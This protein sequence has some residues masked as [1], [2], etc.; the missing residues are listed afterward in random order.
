MLNRRHI[1]IKVM[2]LIY[3]FDGSESDDLEP[4]K[5][6]LIKSME[7]MY[8]LYLLILSLMVEIRL[9]AKDHLQKIQKKHLAT[10][11]DR[12]PSRKFINNSVLKNLASNTKL[13]EC[14]EKRKLNNWKEDNEYVDLLFKLIRNSSIF[15]EYMED[16]T[17]GFG[18]DARFISQIY[19]EIIAPNDKFY[20]YLE[21]KNLTW[22]DDY[23]VVNT[24][25]LKQLRKMRPN[26]EFDIMVPE[27]YKDEEDKQFGLDLLVK[28]LLNLSA[29]NDIVEKKTMNW[30]KDRIAKLDLVLLQMAICEINKFPS[31]PTKV[32]MNEYLEIAK[33]YSTPKSSVFINGILDNLVKE[34]EAKGTLNKAGRGLM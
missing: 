3:A 15:H 23:P 25:F 33:E 9:K 13:M 28:T 29:F 21:D 27:L 18:S 6:Q 11:S 7:G 4:K 5:R 17:I 10:D 19:K 1:R 16:S 12:N 24:V 14:L 26:S 31:I 22:I 8:D 20:E 2:Q 32:T 34:Y 30:D